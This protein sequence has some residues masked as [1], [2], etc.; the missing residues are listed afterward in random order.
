MTNSTIN[1]PILCKQL[2]PV[3]GWYFADSTDITV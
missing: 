1:Q 3:G 2:G